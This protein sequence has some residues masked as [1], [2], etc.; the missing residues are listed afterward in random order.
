MA[1][2]ERSSSVSRV[3]RIGFNV[4]LLIHSN[5][6]DRTTPA[7]DTVA[8]LPPE[9]PHAPARREQS[10]RAPIR[11]AGQN[12]PRRRA[13]FYRQ[14]DAWRF[15]CLSLRPSAGARRPALAR[16]RKSVV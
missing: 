8:L 10:P 7:R 13:F 1:A 2:A 3:P 15:V 11:P 12:G 16:D 14:A 5:P 4:P 6:I 9:L